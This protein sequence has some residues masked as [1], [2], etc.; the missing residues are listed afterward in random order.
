[1]TRYLIGMTIAAAIVCA[2]GWFVLSSFL[3]LGHYIQTVIR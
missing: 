3:G 2:A 1:M